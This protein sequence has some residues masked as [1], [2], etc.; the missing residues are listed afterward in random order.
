MFGR[1]F[2][3]GEDV[4]NLGSD[5]CSCPRNSHVPFRTALFHQKIFLGSR[6]NKEKRGGEGGGGT[7]ERRRRGDAS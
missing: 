1:A 6:M 3:N 4:L 7:Q 5:T 2:V